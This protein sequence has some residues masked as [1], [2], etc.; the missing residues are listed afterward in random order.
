MSLLRKSSLDQ[1]KRINSE[2][3]RQGGKTDR[4]LPSERKMANLISITDPIDSNLDTYDAKIDI[5]EST[6]KIKK[7]DELNSYFEESEEKFLECLPYL[8]KIDNE[9]NMKD[10]IEYL[11][12][13]DI[14]YFGW[15]DIQMIIKYIELKNG[16]ES[17]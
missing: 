14:D 3:K 8:K 9:I 17:K 5:P 11:N 15:S 13:I 6:Y 1:L 12:D 2:I 16:Y 4:A 7:V 10:V